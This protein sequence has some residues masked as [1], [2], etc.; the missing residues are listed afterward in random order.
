MVLGPNDLHLCF[1]EPAESMTVWTGDHQK[2]FQCEAR[3]RTVNEG[4]GHWGHCPPGEFLLGSPIPKREVA[5]GAWFI[6]VLDYADH[7]AMRDFQREGVGIHG[8]GTGL[9]DPYA[10]KQGWQITEGCIRCQNRDLATLVIMVHARQQL[11]G[12]AYLTVS[13]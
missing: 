12:K 11:G 6:P 8:G 10:P 9:P 1:D 5:F 7:H 4:E 3:N 13:A 2:I